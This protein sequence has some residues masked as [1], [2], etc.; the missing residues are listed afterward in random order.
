MRLF[1]SSPHTDELFGAE[2]LHEEQIGSHGMKLSLLASHTHT[3]PGDSLT[4]VEIIG[5]SDL[6]EAKLTRPFIRSRRENLVGRVAFDYHDTVTNVFKDT[7]LTTDRLRI[8]RVGG[9]YNVNDMWSGSDVVDLQISQG[10]SIF[11]AT[12]AGVGR[13]N[14]NGDSGFTK[15][16]MDLA[17][18][19]TLPQ[20][21]SL[22]T[23]ASMQHSFSPLLSDE[24]FTLG[25]TEYARAF[26]PAELL[27]DQG[28]AGKAE[29][30]Y[31]DSVGAKYFDTY[32]LYS[33]YDI[34]RVWL[35]NGAAGSNATSVL[36][37]T[38]VGARLSFTENL[39]ASFEADVPLVKPGNDQTGYRHDPRLFFS[40]NARF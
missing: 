34:G 5:N 4:P 2:I 35:L 18:T 24:Q 17:R 22:L 25:G 7:N 3:A 13:T 12:N 31:T 38:G 6:Y 32:Q 36:S 15:I 40:L 21:F 26:D 20:K 23:A 11:G 14:V 30:R 27:G 37:S 8:A 39:A 19:Q 10:L 33:F 1:T 29:L 28:L 16:N 9:T